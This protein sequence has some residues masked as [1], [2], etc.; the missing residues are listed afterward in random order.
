MSF[1]MGKVESNKSGKGLAKNKLQ[2]KPDSLIVH[3]G[4]PA[5]NNDQHWKR[6][7]SLP[8]FVKPETAILSAWTEH[9]PFA[10]WLVDF[11]KPAT[12][13]ELGTYYG[14]SYFAFCQTILKEKLPTKCYAIDNWIGDEHAGFYENAVFEFVTEKNK[15]YGDFSTI[16]RSS[17][18]DA[19]SQ[20]ED[21]SIDLLH[22]DGLHTYEAVK[23]DFENWLPKLSDQAIVIF[24][25]TN[26]REKGFGV[27]KLWEELSAIYPS[28]EFKHGYGLGIAGVGKNLSPAVRNFFDTVQDPDTIKQVRQVYERLGL[29]YRLEQEYQNLNVSSENKS[30]TSHLNAS[31]LSSAWQPLNVLNTQVYWKNENEDFS[32]A[33]STHRRTELSN[34]RAS[35]SFSLDLDHKTLHRLRIDPSSEE[36]LFYLHS[37]SITDTKGQILLDWE[38]IKHNGK[39]QNLGLIKSGFVEDTFLFFALN[40]DPV[41]EIEFPG[42]NLPGNEIGINIVMTASKPEVDQVHKELIFLTGKAANNISIQ[43]QQY[44]N[45]TENL[46]SL[47]KDVGENLEKQTLNILSEIKGQAIVYVQKIEHSQ[48][49]LLQE[50]ASQ[51][52]A[53]DLLTKEVNAKIEMKDRIIAE[54]LAELRK[55]ESESGILKENVIQLNNELQNLH[56][57]NEGLGREILA[58][59]NSLEGRDLKIAEISELN[60]QLRRQLEEIQNSS[61]LKI[62]RSRLNKGK[63]K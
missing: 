63:K 23:H 55:S 30:S 61:L 34:Q 57:Q 58:G 35:Y 1:F 50:I 53:F 54:T 3:S 22:I 7:T 20:F 37:I 52:E 31:G 17:F 39:F 56:H 62:F 38:T 45:L 4:S 21:N 41:I 25:D 32:E 15:Q 5:K 16:L 27:Y 8:V 6:I 33:N 12:L 9:I 48:A 51:K 18:D 14:L 47:N 36:G 44:I 59:K 10:F 19:V 46:K 42:I 2:D 28:F 24:H 49:T 11:V 43:V 40:D 29:L 26:V 13:V 60:N